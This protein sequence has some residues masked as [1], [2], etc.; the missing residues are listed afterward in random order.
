[1]AWNGSNLPVVQ[2]WGQGWWVW[3]E[4]PLPLTS[5]Q[6]FQ[7]ALDLRI[8]FDSQDRLVF[9]YGFG[10][11]AG[12]LR[13]GVRQVVM[14]VQIGGIDPESRLIFGNGVGQAAGAFGESV[15]QVVVRFR[16]IGIDLQGCLQLGNGGRLDY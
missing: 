12:N 3:V 16:E 2:K 10:L 4:T 9:G 1:V 11:A 6:L 13:K 15:G 8:G 14:R 5:A 7:Y